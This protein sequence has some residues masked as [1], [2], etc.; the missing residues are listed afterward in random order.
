MLRFVIASGFRSALIVEDD[1]DWDFTVRTQMELVSDNVRSFTET[2]DTDLMP[3][4]S[5][6]DVLWIGHC[7]EIPST[8]VPTLQYADDSVL[9]KKQYVGFTKKYHEP[10]KEGHRIVQYVNNTVCTFAY[11]VTSTSAP[12]VLE[13]LSSGQDEG[14]DIAL[15]NK[16][17]NGN[18]RCISVNPEIMHHYKPKEGTGYV[19]L[20]MEGDGLGHAGE[21]DWN[22]FEKLKGTTGNIAFSA[23]C[24]ALFRGTCRKMSND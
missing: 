4:G 8:D 5:G 18:L 9:P 2:P 14:F 20:R 17:C 23:R 24:A 6:W 7:G 21:D 10:L 3:Y 19:S 16:C 12:K 1:V 15:M 22:A 11:A 13:A